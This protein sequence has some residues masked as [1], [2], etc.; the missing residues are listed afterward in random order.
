MKSRWVTT[1]V[2]AALFFSA[3]A[4]AGERFVIEAVLVRVND[5]VLTV[6]DFRKRLEV[7]VAQYPTPPAGEDLRKFALQLFESIVDEMV[8]LERAR[9][10]RIRVEDEMLDRQIEGLREENGLQDDQAFEQALA[11]AGLTED[12]LRDRYRKTMLVQRTA[13]S[14]VSPTEITEEELRQR[15]ETEKE[16]FRIPRRVALEQM[17]FPVAADGSDREQTLRLAQ[18]L[19]E[20]VR[21]GNDFRA[22]ATLAGLEVQDLGSIPD[23][24]LRA[25]LLEVLSRMEPGDLSEPIDTGGGLQVIRLVDRMEAGYEDFDD[26]K[27]AIRR[28][29]SMEAYEEQTRGVVERLKEEYLVEI[30]EDRLTQLFEASGNPA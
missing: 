27:E 5:S 21:N 26:V 3:I 1:A 22:E 9:E 14:E 29:V 7:E 30:F 13:Q 17:F 25:E 11:G 18:A 24:D 8:L 15:Y 28:Q 4:V 16:G 20:R 23:E 2:A 10:K 19:V 12:K 6:G